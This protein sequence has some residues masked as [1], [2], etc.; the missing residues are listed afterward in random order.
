MRPSVDGPQVTS[1]NDARITR[2]GKFL[3]KTKLDELPTFWNVIKGDMALVGPRPEVPRYVKFDDPV[4][5]KVLEVRPGITDPITLQLRNE[6]ELLAHVAGDPEEYYLNEL[7]PQK[8]RAYLEYLQKRNWLTDLKVLGQTLLALI[9]P[10]KD[11]RPLDTHLNHPR[12]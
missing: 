4:W 8:L 9:N 3:R 7:Q 10:Q 5:Q 6:E 12:K 2:A 11:T 1:G